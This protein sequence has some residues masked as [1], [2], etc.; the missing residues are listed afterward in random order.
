MRV[1][2]R[3]AKPI[4]GDQPRWRKQ[5]AR[6]TGGANVDAIGSAIVDANG[7]ANGGANGDAIG[8]IGH[9]VSG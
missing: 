9:I 4:A 5:N 1:V 2:R 6:A 7:G 3:A 8:D